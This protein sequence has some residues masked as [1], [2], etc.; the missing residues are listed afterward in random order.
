MKIEDIKNKRAY[1]SGKIGPA[2]VTDEIRTKFA[3]VARVLKAQGCTVIDPSSDRIQESMDLHFEVN[4]QPP[5]YASILLY[6]LHWLRT[7]T[8]IYMLPD[9]LDSPGAKAEHAFAIA[10]GIEVVYD[11]ELYEKGILRR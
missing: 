8:V 11:E 3:R 2:G 9:F 10:C 6:M 5:H 1:I 4:G 7:C